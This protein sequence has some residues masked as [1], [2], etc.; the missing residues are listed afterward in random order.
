MLAVA[1]MFAAHLGV[2][3]IGLLD[4]DAA[5]L[6]HEL[7]RGR[8]SALFALLAGVSLAL[9]SGGATPLQGTPLR[10]VALRVLVRAVALALLGFVLDLLGTP[11]AV[12]L[13][14]YGGYFLLALPL[15][16]LRAPA[17]ACVAA[18]IALVGP[19]VS[20]VLRAAMGSP[21]PRDGSLGGLGEFFLSGYYPAAT[22]M[23]F[24]VAGM[25][26]GRLDLRGTRVRIGLAAT[27]AGLAALGYGGSRLLMDGL[28]GMS[29]LGLAAWPE[30]PAVDYAQAP[31]EVLGVYR[32][33]VT[34][35]AGDL[36]GTVPVDTAWW[37][38]VATPHSGTTLEIA[39]ATG[40][41]LLTLACCLALADRAGTVLYPMA[42]AGSMA[43][44][45]YTGHIV[46]L[47]LLGTHP[48]DIAPFRLELFILGALVFASCWRP[49][50]GPGPLERG[51]S[52]LSSAMADR[53]APRDPDPTAR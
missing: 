42:A 19:Q 52:S 14:Y 4:G 39:G 23:A 8:S 33:A 15:L 45:V 36:H 43:L 34:E 22:F 40:T 16:L 30:V 26:A 38:L 47:A 32:D 48:D 29:R 9:M 1:G 6:G 10:H 50:L 3:S 2:G 20:F 27:G 11:V 7:A 51:L 41:G 44:T 31:P 24:V 49:L 25:A 5:E 17:L 13:S 18:A 35:W 12:I 53:A 46:V 21:G 37:L 28:D